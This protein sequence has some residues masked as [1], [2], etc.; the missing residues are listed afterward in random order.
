MWT[1]ITGTNLHV[2]DGGIARAHSTI[3][4]GY[5]E[6]HAKPCAAAVDALV[7][8]RVYGGHQAGLI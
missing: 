4:P 7:W 5:R 6:Q 8:H 2:L 3:I 1:T